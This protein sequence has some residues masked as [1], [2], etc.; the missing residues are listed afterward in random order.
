MCHSD[1]MRH[2]EIGSYTV[3][4]KTVHIAFFLE[5]LSPLF[6]FS[7]LTKRAKLLFCT[8]KIFLSITLAS[9]LNE[10]VIFLL[11]KRIVGKCRKSYTSVIKWHNI[12]I[13]PRRQ[14]TKV[15]SYTVVVILSIRLLEVDLIM[16]MLNM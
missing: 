6:H 14:W 1:A 8:S 4:R 3:K 15:Y 9:F 13:S 2:K 10:N 12:M 5:I 16:I 7:L 11:R